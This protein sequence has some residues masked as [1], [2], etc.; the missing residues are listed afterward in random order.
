[1]HELT[2]GQVYLLVE[3]MGE[4]VRLTSPF[5]SGEENDETDDR[6]RQKSLRADEPGALDA[7]VQA[8][9]NLFPRVDIK[10]ITDLK[11][12]DLDALR[13]LTEPN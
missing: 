3:D 8:G 10:K 11:Q 13:R 4:Y 9:V 5:G 6:V 12:D 1:M 2:L 7:M